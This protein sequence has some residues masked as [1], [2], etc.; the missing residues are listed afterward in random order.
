MKESKRLF[1]QYDDD[2]DY[3]DNKVKKRK[4]CHDKLIKP[5]KR[6]M[7]KIQNDDDED[8]DFDGTKIVTTKR[9]DK[10]RAIINKSE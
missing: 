5:R 9:K 1:S 3:K 8:D 2:E 7:D 4:L 6:K 10:K